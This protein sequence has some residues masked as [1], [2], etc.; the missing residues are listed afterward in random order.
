MKILEIKNLTIVNKNTNQ[1][2][3]DNISF[4]LDKGSTLGIV[5]ESGSGKTLTGLSILGLLDKSVFEITQGSIIY[6]GINILGLSEDEIQKIRTKSISIVF[7]EPMLS[8]NPVQK[9]STQLSEVIKLHIDDNPLSQNSIAQDI[10]VKTG[11]DNT[12]KILDSYPHMLSGGQ[13]QR[14]MIAIAL[15]CN[16]DILIADEPTTALDVTLQLQILELLNGIKQEKNMSMVLISHDLDL[17]KNYA[18]KVIILKNGMILEEGLTSKVFS[19]P[20]NSYTKDLI[21]SSPQKLVSE[22]CESSRLLNIESVSCK[23]PVNN[24]FFSKNRKYFTALENVSLYINSGET[25]GLVGESGSGKTTLGLSIMQLLN[26][27]GSIYLDNLEL[28]SLPSKQLRES[29]CDYQIVF[30]DPYSSLSPRMTIFEILSEGIISFNSNISKRE[31]LR[32]CSELI[33]EVGLE[34]SM[35]YRY[36]HQFSGGQRQ[37]IAIARALSMKPKLIIFDEP[38]SALDVIVQ[39]NIL[40]LIVD[41]QKKHSLSYC[42]ISHDLKVISSISHRIYVIKDSRIIETNNTDELISNPQNDYTKK[43]IE[44]SF[45]V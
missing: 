7:Q 15:V 25:I 13:R 31:L 28:S 35:L 18:D 1:I 3:L 32:I 38:T 27:S 2:L 14:I 19:Q 22:S 43:L 10:L 24:A 12:Q 34:K 16:P 23:F 45:I 4:I 36:P 20:I 44:S 8:L 42:F 41:L 40:K 33:K 21:A 6:D 26:Y 17:I 29:R 11:L 30:Q 9:I 5:G 39:K 37:R